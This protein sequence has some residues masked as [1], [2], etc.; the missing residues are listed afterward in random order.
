MSPTYF[1]KTFGCQMN[2]S[3]SERLASFLEK[4]NF[5]PSLKIDKANLVIFNSCGV[6]KMAE[7]RAFG[8]IHNLR[9]NNPNIKIALTGC[10]SQRKDVQ[11]T[12]AKK[13]DLFFPINNFDELGKFINI[14][15]NNIKLKLKNSKLIRNS[16]L[17]IQNFNSD[18]NKINYLSITPNYAHKFQANVP[19]MTGCNNFCAYCVVPYARGREVSRGAD[20]IIKEI[21]NLLKNGCQEITLL[22]QNVNS[23]N[24]ELQIK[25][26]KL[27]NNINFSQLLHLVNNLP[28]NFWIRFMSSHPKDM[29]DELIQTIT[30][31]DKV[32]ESVHLPIQSGDDTVLKNM[33]RKYTQKHY[34]NL[35][36]KIKASFEKNKPAKL[37]SISSDIIVGFPGET[38]LQ[39]EKSAQVMRKAN[40]DMA[41]FGQFSP[42]PQT[43]AW[44]MKDNVTKPEKERREK[45][46][47]EILK[48]TALANNKKYLGK[49]IDVLIENKKG[50]FYFGKTRTFKNIRA[51]I[52]KDYCPELVRPRVSLAS[53]V[54]QGS[55][56]EK[57]HPEQNCHLEQSCH[58]ELV[59]GSLIGKIIPVK[60]TQAKIWSLEGEIK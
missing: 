56:S 28:G 8:Q 16:K 12:L 42:R 39:L 22:G 29:S 53:A 54:A 57:C 10:I 30:S 32:C 36:K 48:K 35:I 3:D 44:K 27:K 37:Y 60:I 19:I 58:P 20:E 45:Y 41:Y 49:T 59:S 15:F 6:R 21:K 9:K 47:N 13:V 17:K 46:L 40:Y 24:G 34:L 1:I 5:K 7:D 55:Q 51:I 38:K 25:N 31:L 14:N 50:E 4:N 33:N 52:H 26:S 2:F 11:L 23:Y 43:I 18:N